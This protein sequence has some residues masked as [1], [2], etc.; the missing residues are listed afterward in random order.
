MFGLKGELRDVEAGNV[1]RSSIGGSAFLSEGMDIPNCRNCGTGL[2]L[3]LQFDIGD[4]WDV[5]IEAG[6]HLVLF[7][8]PRCNEIPSFNQYPTGQLPQEFWN[9]T[10]GHFFAALFPAGTATKQIAQQP[11][12]ITKE[13]VFET[14]ATQSDLTQYIRVGGEP[15]WLQDPE[16]FTCACGANM[17]F[18]GQIPEDLG[19]QKQDDAPEQPDSFSA[20][21]Y[22]LFLGNEVYIFACSRECNPRSVWM[23]VQGS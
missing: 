12:L 20:D 15:Y 16:K 9:A 22:C 18:I 23:T 8:C 11:L 21:E 19:F 13:L 17:A 10:K 4:E 2:F 14:D 5:A 1:P 7:T 6:S 3:F